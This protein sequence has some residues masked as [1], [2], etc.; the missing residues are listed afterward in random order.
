VNGLPAACDP[1]RLGIDRVDITGVEALREEHGH[2]VYRVVCGARSWVLKWFPEGGAAAEVENYA[3]LERLGVPTLPVRARTPNALLLEDLAVSPNRRLASAVDAT[4]PAAG[5]AV[6]A[7]YR[8][9]H[10]AGRAVVTARGGPPPH[11]KREADALDA[12]VLRGVG[13]RFDLTGAPGW[14]LCLD[15]V[16]ALKAALRTLP[17]TLTYGDFRWT[18][19]ALAR[20]APGRAVVFDLHLLGLGPAESDVRN[21]RTALGPAA[22]AAFAEA[23]GP[24]DARALA[25]DAPLALL[26]ALREAGRRPTLPRW[27]RPRSRPC[28]P[29]T[30]SAAPGGRS[31]PSEPMDRGVGRREPTGGTGWTVPRQRGSSRS[32]TLVLSP[33]AA[34]SVSTARAWRR[35]YDQARQR[36][37]AASTKRAA[38]RPARRRRRPRRG[39]GSGLRRRETGRSRRG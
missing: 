27:E 15:A 2:A 38:S 33:S 30:W 23:Y 20:D 25:L 13:E 16:G 22:W 6:A 10:R 17:E 8:A 7:W 19:L 18:N 35:L 14:A 26:H 36:S 28:G 39:G 9:L 1:G 12:G 21:V 24:V 3:L 29:A 34:R 32:R 11:L 31:P 4:E 37:P 5:A